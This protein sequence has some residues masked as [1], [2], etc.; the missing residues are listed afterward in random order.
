LEEQK[1]DQKK[2]R[3]LSKAF[4]LYDRQKRSS[5]TLADSMDGLIDQVRR[6]VDNLG[7]DDGGVRDDD[8]DDDDEFDRAQ[9]SQ[10]KKRKAAKR[11]SNKSIK[12]RQSNQKKRSTGRQNVS[13][14]HS[15]NQ[16]TGARRDDGG[17]SSGDEADEEYV[18]SVIAGNKRLRSQFMDHDEIEKESD[19]DRDGGDG[20]DDD[21]E[22]RF[23]NMMDRENSSEPASKRQ[24]L[25][26][27][28][29]ESPHSS[30]SSSPLARRR[31]QPPKKFSDPPA[32]SL[33]LA[34]LLTQELPSSAVM[35][36]R[37]R[38]R[39]IVCDDEED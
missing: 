8:D 18:R 22:N 15:I 2:Q 26:H 10:R 14:E 4:S 3:A 9:Q 35:P 1:F 13:G 6:V 25:F 17:E 5:S 20:D 27:V 11:R 31:A 21:E 29:A 36:S 19:R 24:K 7:D 37:Q 39:N 28:P 12:R 30:P 32:P 23:I 16:K 38:S 33:E 34:P